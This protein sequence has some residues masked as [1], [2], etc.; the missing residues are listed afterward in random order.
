[1]SKERKKQSVK[2]GEVAGNAVYFIIKIV[3]VIVAVMFIYRLGTMAYAYGERLFGEPPM[4]TEPGNEVVFTI[5]P[6][7]DVKAVGEK[8]KDA[9]LIRDVTLFCIQEKLLGT[10]NGL[11][12]GT[13]TLNTAQTPEEMIQLMSTVRAGEKETEQQDDG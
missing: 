9:G 8:M 7:D 13:Y 5:E 4:T 2:K 1:M 3:A 12:P 11:Q 10:K 6:S